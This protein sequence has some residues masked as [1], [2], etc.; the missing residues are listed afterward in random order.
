LEFLKLLSYV[1]SAEN[2]ERLGTFHGHSGAVWSVDVSQDS[3][4]VITGS[5]DNSAKIWESNTGRE[6][7][8]FP[9]KT[10]VRSVG[11]GLGEKQFLTVT[12]QV[13]GF[14]PTINVWDYQERHSKPV[15][16]ITG[17]NEAKILQAVWAP[18]NREIITANEDGTVRVYDIRTGGQTKVITDHQKAVM[19]ITFSKNQLLFATAS[20]DGT[21][22]LYDTKTFAHLKTFTTGRPINAVSISPIREEIIVGGGQAAETVTTSRVDNAQF[23]V[24]FYHLIF[25]EELASVQGHFGPVNILSYSPD[26]KS[27]ASGGEDGYVRIHHF[28]PSYFTEFGK[29]N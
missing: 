14:L 9:H 10:P 17:K 2:G 5:A 4:T 12:D 24:R 23:R 11:F 21:S 22:K 8:S 1:W 18:L 7:Q 13:L 28:D 3:R 15:I 27:F 16:E 25:E 6:L 20:K 26:G 29:D 19:H